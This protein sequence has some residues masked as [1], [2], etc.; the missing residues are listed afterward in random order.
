MSNVLCSLLKKKNLIPAKQTRVLF[1]LFFLS[2]QYI[3]LYCWSVMKVGL[4]RGKIDYKGFLAF[5]I[6]SK[7]SF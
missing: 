4:G 6:E 1:L 2:F 5:N 3:D 7:I